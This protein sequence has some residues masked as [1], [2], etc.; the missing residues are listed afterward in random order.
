M[1]DISEQAII[2]AIEANL[3]EEM[4]SFG[5]YLAGAELHE[6]AEMQWIITDLFNAVIRTQITG[7]DI[8]ARLDATLA[9]FKSRGVTTMGWAVSPSTQPTNLVTYLQ[10]RGCKH[11]QDQM[12]MAAD[13][14]ALHEDVTTPANLHITRVSDETMLQTYAHVSMR[15]FGSSEDKI[16]C[17]YDTYA[18]I[19]FGEHIAWQHFVG[20]LDDE[21]V[22]VSSLLLHGGVAGVY[23][24][25]T[26][27]E[28]RRQG[29]GTAMTLAALREA[30]QRG[31]HLGILTPSDMG[32]GIYRRLGFRVYYTMSIY[33]LSL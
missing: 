28:A 31:Y 11:F 13:L 10:A 32:L 29:A 25:A 21:P 6:D 17:Y 20:W 24:V 30:R 1:Q 22:A 7:A 4:A 26:I 27:P 2:A 19:G 33:G 15:G 23:G 16:R 12:G 8:D 5:R 9:H 18:R 3:A 14:Q